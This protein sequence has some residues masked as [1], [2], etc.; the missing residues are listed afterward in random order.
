MTNINMGLL[1][2]L[3]FYGL[4]VG[5]FLNVVACRIPKL[6]SIISPPSHCPNCQTRLRP[7]DL[8]PVFSWL[9]LRGKCRYCKAAIHWQYPA[10]EAFT[11]ISWAVVAWRYGWSWE[12]FMGLGF[13]SFLIPLS[14]IDIREM[15]LPNLLTYPLIGFALMGRLAVGSEPV[16]SYLAGGIF[17]AGFLLFLWRVSPYLFGKEGMGLGDVK[18]MAGI[19]LMVGMKGTILTLFASSFLGLIV[20]L[21]LQKANRL[22][23]Q[24]YVPFGPF[25]A[26]GGTV[27]FLFGNEIWQAYESLFF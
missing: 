21:I 6:E 14:I 15:L 8:I 1:L 26:L 24:Q 9:F 3:S 12:T 11:A 5:S 13:V 25:L 19:G 27:S 18:L 4:L 22:S 2:L 17:G 20:G 16:W 7:L 10:V 23:Q